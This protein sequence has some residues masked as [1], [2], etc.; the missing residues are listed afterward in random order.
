MLLLASATTPA[1]RPAN[2]RPPAEQPAATVSQSRN[3]SFPPKRVYSYKGKI[4][5]TYHKF[6][7]VTA[8]QLSYVP[9]PPANLR[10]SRH[11][12]E[13]RA[14]FSFRGQT[15]TAIPQQ[16]MF[17][18]RSE[19]DNRYALVKSYRWLFTE[20]RDLTFL[21]DGEPL[22]VGTM[23]H[24]GEVTDDG[25]VESL[26][27][28]IPTAAFLQIVN[29]KELEMQVGVYEMKL[30]DMQL[31]ALRDFTSRMNP[32]NKFAPDEVTNIPP[33]DKP[34]PK[35]EYVNAKLIDR[36]LPAYPAIGKAAR[37][38]GKVQVEVRVDEK[39]DVISATAVSGHAMLRQAAEAAAKGAK[40]SPAAVSGQATKTS[41]T[42]T[43]E[44]VC[45]AKFRVCEGK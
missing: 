26:S 12:M 8:V 44:F 21:V 36:P 29:A 43:Y 3:L 13:L 41:A 9:L 16:M 24:K 25:L 20:L 14:I 42:L 6:Q 40:F 7:G 5:T 32:L 34:A 33:E 31:D 38:S 15:L 10:E 22:R 30:G 19:V 1:Q 45:D 11:N 28:Y 2:N 39:G 23:E 18:I 27:I 4:E 17:L 37:A 35:L